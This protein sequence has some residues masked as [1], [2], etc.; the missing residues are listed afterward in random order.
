LLFT[1]KKQQA[2]IPIDMV[3]GVSIDTFMGALW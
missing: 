2:G 3:G 1:L